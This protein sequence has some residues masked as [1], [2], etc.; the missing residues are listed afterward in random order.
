[1]YICA[2]L[3]YTQRKVKLYGSQFYWKQSMC[4]VQKTVSIGTKEKGRINKEN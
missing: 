4:A 2:C 3:R 1:M